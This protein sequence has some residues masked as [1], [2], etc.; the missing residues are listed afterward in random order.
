MNSNGSDAAAGAG[1]GVFIFLLLGVFG[2]AFYFLPTIVAVIRDHKNMGAIG[3]LNVFLGWT[4][5]GWAG[6]LAWACTNPVDTPSVVV[7][8]APIAPIS[9]PQGWYPDPYGSG[10]NRWWDGVQWTS[11]LS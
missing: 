2:M 8:Q 7:M 3:V 1:V 4:L 11:H 5:V 10:R 9:T 6:A